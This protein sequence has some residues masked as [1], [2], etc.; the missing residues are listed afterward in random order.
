[1]HGQS[2][3]GRLGA[4]GVGRPSKRLSQAFLD[5][6]SIASAIV[7]DAALTKTEEV[8]EVGPGLGV[9]TDLL[10][11][12]VRR[13]VAVEIDTRLADALRTQ[14][15]DRHNLIVE[16]ADILAVDPSSYFD[17]S[18]VVVANL[19][20][21]I[22]SPSLRHL[23]AVGPPFASRLIVMVQAEVADRIAA[24]PGGLSALAVTIQTQARVAVLRRVP[25][26]AFFPKPKVESAVL[27]L[28]P[29]ADCE[30]A[31]ARA[32]MPAFTRLVQAGFKQPRKT[33]ANSL[34]DGL[35]LSR[36]AAVE[37]LTRV[38]IDAS[39]RPQAL[40]LDDWV[41]LFRAR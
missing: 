24:Q 31:L 19:P 41:R 8:L 5:D 12:S 18:F 36:E 22:T 21:H 6:R 34:A 32:E 40:Q 10:A 11:D 39:L 7:R 27:R 17:Q 16:T 30:R 38:G 15:A 35:Q 20:Y 2:S 33:V 1:V 13:V 3:R 26:T 14:Y 29:I 4:L 37:Q 28:E 25:A 9:L 23:L